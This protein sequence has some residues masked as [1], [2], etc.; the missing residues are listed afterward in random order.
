MWQF[1]ISTLLQS[2]SI[3]T[4]KRNERIAGA[5]RCDTIPSTF[6]KKDAI[7]ADGENSAFTDADMWFQAS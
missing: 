6:V 1:F 4:R 7:Q 5:V 2:K 3:T